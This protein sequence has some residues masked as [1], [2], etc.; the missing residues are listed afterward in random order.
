MQEQPIDAEDA[1]LMGSFETDKKR[2]GSFTEK[3]GLL[4]R[5]FY[6]AILAAISIAIY[7]FVAITPSL[8]SEASDAN[9]SGTYKDP[10]H[11]EGY[12]VITLSGLE[13]TVKGVDNKDDVEEWTASGTVEGN[14]IQVDFT[15]KGGPVI[16]GQYTVDGILFEDGNLWSRT[17]SNDSNMGVFKVGTV[18]TVRGVD[19][20]MDGAEDGSNGVGRSVQSLEFGKAALGAEDL[21]RQ[22]AHGTCVHAPEKDEPLRW[23]CGYKKADQIACFNRHYAEYMGYWT[24]ETTFLQDESEASGEITFYDVI[25]GKPLFVA[26][27]GR[28]WDEFVDESKAHGWPS[29]RNE[30]VVAENVRVL[31]NGE[32]VSVDGTHLGHNLPDWK[33]DRYCINLVSVAGRPMPGQEL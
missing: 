33:G 15:P 32:A 13:A 16:S 31:K 9:F 14:E 4:Q 17:N 19:A 20:E 18:E 12:R 23:G 5:L 28:T 1:Q 24:G 27:R 10:N 25:T 21:M 11:P 30:E 26:P 7:S 8:S 6:I 22:K 2:N 29:F 3:H